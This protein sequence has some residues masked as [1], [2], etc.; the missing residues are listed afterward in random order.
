MQVSLDARSR[1]RSVIRTCSPRYTCRYARRSSVLF[2]WCPLYIHSRSSIS[3]SR[4]ARR[5]QQ[6]QLAFF[7][8]RQ[9]SAGGQQLAFAPNLVR[10][11][12]L[13]LQ[14]ELCEALAFGLVQRHQLACRLAPFE[15]SAHRRR[16]SRRHIAS[17]HDLYRRVPYRPERCLVGGAQPR[18]PHVVL[19]RV[20][21][22]VAAGDA[23][24]FRFHAVRRGAALVPVLDPVPAA[25]SAATL[26]Y[27]VASIAITRQPIVRVVLRMVPSCFSVS[28]GV[29]R[30]WPGSR[31]GTLGRPSPVPLS[32][33]LAPIPSARDCGSLS[34]RDGQR[35][36]VVRRCPLLCS[37]LSQPPACRRLRYRFDAPG[38]GAGD[39][40]GAESADS[41]PGARR[42]A[43]A[44]AAPAVIEHLETL[45][46]RCTR[47]PGVQLLSDEA[48]T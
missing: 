1:S 28:V 17:P 6:F 39:P 42:D 10:F 36:L 43:A 48:R 12:A 29:P 46:A 8:G 14:A 26:A 22:V 15:P 44:V 38:V 30:G 24:D 13:P 9:V 31:P 21:S 34:V 23:V 27:P 2:P 16:M 40:F 47:L 37:A 33:L 5:W 3:L 32:H 18:D 25:A 7:P 11:K 35:R 19:R 4:V 20:P 41:D 45:R